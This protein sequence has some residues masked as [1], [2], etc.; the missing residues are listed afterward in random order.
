MPELKMDEIEAEIEKELER[1]GDISDIDENAS[2]Y[3]VEAQLS[4]DTDQQN[5][6]VC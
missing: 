2:D 5:I 3:S 6:Q 1:I 4:L